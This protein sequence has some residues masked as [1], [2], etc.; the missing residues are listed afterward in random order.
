MSSL[1]AVPK[2]VKG[3]H[4]SLL[5]IQKSGLLRI[6]KTLEGDPVEAQKMFEK[7][8]TKLKKGVGKSHDAEKLG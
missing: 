2:I 1:S 6:L 3:G 8:L 7:S 5:R 4:L